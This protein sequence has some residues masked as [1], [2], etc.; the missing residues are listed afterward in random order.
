MTK[1]EFRTDI[2]SGKTITINCYSFRKFSNSYFYSTPTQTEDSFNNFENFWNC[3]SIFVQDFNKYQN[4]PS[5]DEIDEQAEREGEA[6]EKSKKY[7]IWQPRRKSE[8]KLIKNR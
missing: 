2:E 8:I 5:E 4:Y 1:E 3:I 6:K 7:E